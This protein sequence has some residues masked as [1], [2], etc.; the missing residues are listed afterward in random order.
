MLDLEELSD[1][2]AKVLSSGEK[3]RL[4][5]ARAIVLRPEILFLDEPTANLDPMSMAK[6]EEIVKNASNS[7]VKIIFITHDI[8]QAK[9]LSDDIIF[10]HKGKLT[11]YTK[12]EIFFKSPNSIE[13]TSYLE[14][15]IVL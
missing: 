13:A 5:L 2:P 8:G 11:E 3:Q 14:G 10:I 12:K 9:R 6:I 7:G 15:K 1:K 4:A